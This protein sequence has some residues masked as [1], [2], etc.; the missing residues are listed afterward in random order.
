[1]RQG[2][3]WAVGLLCALGVLA[4]GGYPW[5]VGSVKVGAEIDRAIP[6]PLGLHWRGPASAT[7]ALLPWPTLRVRGVDLV[8]AGDRNVLSAPAAQFPLSLK[9][10]LGGRFVP[11]GATLQ[12]P[13]RVHRPRRRARRRRGGATPVD[14]RERRASRLVVARAGSPRR[15]VAYRQR[16]PQLRRPDR[17]PRGIA[18]LA[19]RRR[20]DGLRHRRRMAQRGRKDRRQ[21]RQ[22]AAG[23]EKEPDRR[24]AGDRL[25][26]PRPRLERD[27]G[28]RRRRG[29][30]RRLRR[31]CQLADCAGA[32][33]R[34]RPRA[35]DRRRYAFRLGQGADE[36]RFARAERR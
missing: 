35:A 15:R 32:P 17:A 23:L 25:A 4:C 16:R 20:A 10:L 22:T 14:G 8:D 18:R 7:L 21:D 9:G 24:A 11:V 6:P 27:V 30:R 19:E 5:P 1:M 36:R 33:F 3:K 31:A 13:D 34:R 26:S 12:R 2:V 28:R 29:V